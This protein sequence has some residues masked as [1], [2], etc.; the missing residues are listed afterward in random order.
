MKSPDLFSSIVNLG[1]EQMSPIQ[2][3]ITPRT[4]AKTN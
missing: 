2:L 1:C 4:S 3:S